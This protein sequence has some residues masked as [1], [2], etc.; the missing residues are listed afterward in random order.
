MG[1]LVRYGKLDFGLQVGDIWNGRCRRRDVGEGI[2]T[3][4]IALRR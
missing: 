1:A 4:G 3:G 2:L